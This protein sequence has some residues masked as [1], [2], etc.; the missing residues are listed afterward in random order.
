MQLSIYLH[1][2]IV[3]IL[4]CYG[5]LNTVINRILRE[6]AA[7]KFD[8]MHKP[9]APSRETASRYDITITEPSYLELLDV[10]GPHSSKIS[11]RRV[12]YWFVDN[13]MYDEFEWEQIQVFQDK[14]KQ[15][16]LKKLQ[17]AISELEKAKRY[18]TDSLTIQLSDICNS[19]KGLKEELQDEK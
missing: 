12:I 6:A 18:C 2:Q 5:D 3:E 9:P 7:G 15:L 1:R 11:I 10:Y 8:V 19:I 16:L 17:Y 14:H 13:E 4:T